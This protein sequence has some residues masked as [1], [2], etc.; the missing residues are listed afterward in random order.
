MLKKIRVDQLQTGMYVHDLHCDWMEH[1]FLRPRFLLKTDTHLEQIRQLGIHELTI[2]TKKGQDLSNLISRTEDQPPTQPPESGSSPARQASPTDERAHAKRIHTEAI[3]VVSS[4]MTD[5]RL[6]QQI[7]LERANPVIGEMVDSIFRN[8]D[9]LLGLTRI[10]NMDRYTFEHSVNVAVLMVSFARSLELDRPLIQ[11][12]GI[13]A[14]L[15]D[16]G[17]TLVPTAI[18][19]KPGRLSDEEFGVMRG[20]VVHSREILAVAPGIPA[21]ALAVAAEHHERLDGSGYPD[22]KAGAAI[23]RYGQMAAIVDI[24]DA[25]T[26]DRVY[27]KGMEPPLALRKLLEWSGQHVDPQLVQQF[28]RCV[29]IYPVGTLVRLRSGRLGVVVESSREGLLQPVV[30]VFMDADRRRYLAVQDVD[31]S[32]QRKGSEERIERAESPEQWHVNP[33]ELLQM[34]C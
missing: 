20:H 23:S 26:S 1:G 24:Y 12:I 34:R 9:A 28:I 22:G 31:L 10:R 3:D 8:Q 7:D 16:L 5:A 14:L 17:K 32:R 4:L 2:D 18:L 29:G 33:A 27:H 25:I 15:H 6:G 21:A 13:G 11:D 30:R 19:N